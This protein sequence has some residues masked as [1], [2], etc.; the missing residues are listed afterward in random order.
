[1]FLCAIKYEA[2]DP[3]E[4]VSSPIEA[5]ALSASSHRFFHH[6]QHLHHYYQHHQ[7]LVFYKP[8]PKMRKSKIVFICKQLQNKKCYAIRHQCYPV[9]YSRKC[10]AH[11]SKF[12]AHYFCKTDKVAIS[13][14]QVFCTTIFINFV[15][16]T[17]TAG[18]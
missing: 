6:L 13:A 17:S 16:S 5:V 8:W 12:M 4:V 15:L 10:A 1:M 18:F 3:I 7:Q 2:S 9:G 14:T 11:L